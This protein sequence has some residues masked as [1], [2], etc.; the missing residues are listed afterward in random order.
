MRTKGKTSNEDMLKVVR[1][2][3]NDPRNLVYIMSGRTRDSLDEVFGTLDSVGL[4]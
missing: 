3:A 2:L 1:H 4:W